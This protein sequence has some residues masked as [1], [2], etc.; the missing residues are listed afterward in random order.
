MSDKKNPQVR[1]TEFNTAKNKASVLS[2]EITTLKRVIEQDR[3]S[4]KRDKALA[5][6]NESLSKLISVLI[7]LHQNRI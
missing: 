6:Q 2:R 3:N 5:K 1:S 4:T 7:A